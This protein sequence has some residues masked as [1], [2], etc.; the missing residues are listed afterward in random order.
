MHFLPHT[1]PYLSLATVNLPGKCHRATDAEAEGV[2][3]SV[4]FRLSGVH[5]P[6]GGAR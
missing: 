5:E 3:T 2:F 1:L 6:L 4:L